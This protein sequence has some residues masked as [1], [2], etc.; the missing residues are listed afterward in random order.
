M[1]RT[2]DLCADLGEGFG[3]Y[4]ITND[5][6]LIE[7][8]S[9]ANIACGFHAG[10]PRTIQKSVQTAIKSRT[11]VGAHPGFPD[12]VGFGRRDMQLSYEE[13]YTD[14]LYQIGAVY[15]FAKAN[16]GTLQ[17]VMAHGQLQNMA[18]YNEVYAEAITDAVK[19]FDA[20]TILM[21]MPGKLAEIA[22]KKQLNIATVIFA[23]RRY[24]DDKSLVSRNEKNA[25]IRDIDEIIENI[26]NLVINYKAISINGKELEI[27]GDSLLLH[28]DTPGSLIIARK[29]KEALLDAGVEI[30]PLLTWDKYK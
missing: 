16:N 8:I 26:L 11:G 14:V 4:N 3:R 5:A 19:D 28:G 1:P 22:Q 29:I 27:I 23:D 15:A 30:K 12:R 13:V 10:D 24:N 18:Q 25:V 6:E 2:I 21:C 9:S 20:K 7:I 17:H